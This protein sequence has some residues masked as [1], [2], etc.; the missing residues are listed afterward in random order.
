MSGDD[1]FPDPEPVDPASR[2]R[3]G[4]R[5][6][7][8]R[9]AR[10]SRAFRSSESASLALYEAADLDCGSLGLLHCDLALTLFA[11]PLSLLS[12]GLVVLCGDRSRLPLCAAAEITECWF[13]DEERGWAEV[14]AF[15]ARGRYRSRA[16]ILPGERV[17]PQLWPDLQ[18]V[19][20]DPDPDS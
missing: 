17:A 10:L 4:A 3:N 20:F 19:P 9:I 15:P 1:R 6:D 12:V 14:F 13:I 16:L 8:C 18:L 5:G 2:Q 7:P 11:A